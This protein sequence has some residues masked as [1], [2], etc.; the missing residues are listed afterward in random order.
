MASH[1]EPFFFVSHLFV[2]YKC[3]I[4]N[5]LYY[6]S[7]KS[8]GSGNI[9]IVYLI[10]NLISIL[11]FALHIKLN[12]SLKNYRFKKVELLVLFFV[13]P[14]RYFSPVTLRKLV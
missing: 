14:I 9:F 10:N 4:L 6:I 2:P 13:I 7:G 3:L 5:I 12:L 11:Q 1:N 8:S